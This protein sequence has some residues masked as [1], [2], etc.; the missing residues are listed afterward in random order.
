M[1]SVG[2]YDAKTNLPRLLDEV[3]AGETVTI[4]KHGKPIA[5]IVPIPQV[6]SD[7]DETIEA[8]ME[9]RKGNRLDGLSIKD[10]IEEGRR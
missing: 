9:F 8:I 10:R 1:K 2:V 4:T 6:P 5:R 7:I 3:Q